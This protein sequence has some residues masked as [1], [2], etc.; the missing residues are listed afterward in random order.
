[1]K[2]G[3]KVYSPELKKE[4][5]VKEV[6]GNAILTEEGCTLSSK[7]VI[8]SFSIEDSGT[9]RKKIKDSFDCITSRLRKSKYPDYHNEDG[10]IDK[11]ANQEFED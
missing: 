1:M 5:T 8:E 9:L 7:M 11:I 2:P 3:T 4:F 6:K 10:N